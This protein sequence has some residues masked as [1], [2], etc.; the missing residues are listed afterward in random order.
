MTD[1]DWENDTN[2]WCADCSI[3]TGIIGEYY[4]VTHDLWHKYGVVRGMLCL[5]CLE[6]RVGRRLCASDFPDL[7]VNNPF[8]V[9]KSD[10][11]LSRMTT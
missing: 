1:D 9:W 7:P 4:M 2:W 11:A 3:H 8:R 10:F 5:S 6:S